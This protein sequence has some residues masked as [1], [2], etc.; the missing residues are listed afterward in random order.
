MVGS[1]DSRSIALRVRRSH[2]RRR[3]SAAP[4]SR[5]A[6]APLCTPAARIQVDRSGP[7]CL[8]R[9]SWRYTGNLRISVVFSLD[10]AIG[11]LNVEQLTPRGTANATTLP[12]PRSQPFVESQ[13]TWRCPYKLIESWSRAY[14]ESRPH[15]SLGNR[16]PASSPVRAQLAAL[17][18][19]NN[20]AED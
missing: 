3:R 8:G 18:L 15:A 12:S 16:T 7:G 14:N 9:C 17:S 13:T 10:S 19:P 6:A 4:R 20:R 1:G 5:S 2:W 11:Y